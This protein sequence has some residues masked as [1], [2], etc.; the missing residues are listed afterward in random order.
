M[1]GAQLIKSWR[2]QISF[3]IKFY[4]ELRVDKLLNLTEP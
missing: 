4:I 2:K 3:K 1:R